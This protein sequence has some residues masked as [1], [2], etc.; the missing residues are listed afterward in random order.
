VAPCA[1]S[2]V[3]AQHRDGGSAVW[4]WRA[5]S[6]IWDASGAISRGQAQ[7][8]RQPMAHG[9]SLRHRRRAAAAG[10]RGRTLA[11]AV[12]L[13]HGHEAQSGARAQL[14]QPMRGIRCQLRRDVDEAA[15]Y[16]PVMAPRLWGAA[17]A[18]CSVKPLGPVLAALHNC[19][20]WRLCC[21]AC[22]S[23]EVAT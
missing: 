22:A 9:R 6:C 3:S 19:Q 18:V 13:V 2:R 10:A 20:A 4:R 23:T 16:G 14:L 1:P 12:R 11:H 17:G 8:R 5:W 15:A 21:A 7:A